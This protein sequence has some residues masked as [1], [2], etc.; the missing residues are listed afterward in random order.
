MEGVSRRIEVP[1][2]SRS[3]DVSAHR[4]KPNIALQIL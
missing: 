3:G 4:A 2:P 1:E